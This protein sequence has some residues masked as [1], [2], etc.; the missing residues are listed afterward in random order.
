M[1]E[2]GANEDVRRS[3][4]D[5]ERGRK[6]ESVRHRVVTDRTVTQSAVTQGIHDIYQP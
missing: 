1:T 2:D 6:G 4:W 3:R 5:P